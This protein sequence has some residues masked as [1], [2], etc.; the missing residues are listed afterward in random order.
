[1]LAYGR[2]LDAKDARAINLCMQE[3]FVSAID[4]A[5]VDKHWDLIEDEEHDASSQQV[6]HILATLY[7]RHMLY[8]TYEE[9]DA[10]SQQVRHMLATLYT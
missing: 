8:A 6:R 10:S 4:W 7:M 1:M 5:A 3:L 9:H 2:C